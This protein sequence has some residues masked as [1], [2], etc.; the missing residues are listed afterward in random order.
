[1]RTRWPHLLTV[2]GL[3][4]IAYGGVALL[5]GDPLTG[6]YNR[7]EQRRL[8]SE[9]ASRPF[10]STTVAPAARPRR[11]R[12][13][14]IAVP[15]L[16][17]TQGKPLGWITIP[18][19]GVKAIFVEGTRSADLRKG[20]GHYE[21][22]ALPGSGRTVAIAGHR[23]TY[24]AFFRH[25][26]ELRPGDRITLRLGYGEFRYVVFGHRIVDR[27]DWS[28]I[29]GRRFETLVLSACHP[30]YSAEQR[31]VVFARLA[32]ETKPRRQPR[33]RPARARASASYEAT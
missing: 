3:C 19:I 9:L 28:I 14:P 16:H 33:A 18:A 13:A 24:G 10:I 26:D 12:P 15:R 30:L 7:L 31:W 23:T 22:T 27:R 6:A 29:R 11:K 4:L 1:M 17:L 25:I 32:D 21:M 20:P 2:V 5:Q 8:A